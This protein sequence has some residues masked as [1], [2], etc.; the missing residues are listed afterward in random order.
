[1]QH[2]VERPPAARP[3]VIEVFGEPLGVAIPTG[4]KYRF[5]AVKLPVFAIDGVEFDSLEDARAAASAAAH[6]S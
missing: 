4:E 5:V 3:I 6:R 1:M 2:P